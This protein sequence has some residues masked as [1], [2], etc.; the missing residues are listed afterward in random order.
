MFA[1]LVADAANDTDRLSEE[2]LHQAQHFLNVL[3]HHQNLG[4]LVQVSNPVC[5]EDVLTDRWPGSLH[6]Q[7]MFIS[8]LEYLV[9]QVER[10]IEGCD[11]AEM[12]KIM[13]GLFGESPTAEAF[14]TFNEQVGGI[15]RDGQ[16][17]HRPGAGGLIL[18]GAASV[19]T[20]A[21]AARATPKHTFFGEDDEDRWT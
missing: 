4:H 13:T 16:S 6:E 11:L 10:L 5:N 9:R 12:Q 7:A 21:S 17:Q 8:D 18:P 15:V 19:I 1:K 3:Q 14:R 2:M 20:T